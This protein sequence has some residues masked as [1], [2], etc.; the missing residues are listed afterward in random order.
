MHLLYAFSLILPFLNPLKASVLNPGKEE[1][2]PYLTVGKHRFDT[3][4][5]VF[6]FSQTLGLQRCFQFLQ[7]FL[8]SSQRKNLWKS[9]SFTK[10]FQNW[11]EKDRHQFVSWIPGEERRTL[12]HELSEEEVATYKKALKKR[13][14]L[15][16]D[17]ADQL[18]F[19]SNRLF[20]VTNLPKEFK[21]TEVYSNNL[22]D[23]IVR[24]LKGAFLV[25]NGK[26]VSTL[27]C[28]VPLL[29]NMLKIESTL[30]TLLA[31][32][33]AWDPFAREKSHSPQFLEFLLGLY[34]AQ[35]LDKA[36]ILVEESLQKRTE[37]KKKWLSTLKQYCGDSKVHLI[38]DALKKN[39]EES[40]Y[41]GYRCLLQSL[42]F[43]TYDVAIQS[44]LLTYVQ[45]D[46]FNTRDWE[47]LSGLIQDYKI[48]QEALAN[49]TAKISFLEKQ[50]H[51]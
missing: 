16:L 34:G 3:Q 40:F 39:W 41:G 26:K 15:E 37:E 12:F 4:E 7:G 23:V 51:S 29:D 35:S 44:L 36:L 17:E 6:H 20:L 14:S 30:F 47:R 9:S 49:S 11:P 42:F 18:R 43:Y 25:L 46:P 13:P 10:I 24:R 28:T 2:P 21:Q 22:K 1:A 45:G 50:K 32:E 33:Y 5:E 31:K 38:T 48:I 19:F 8:T 27:A